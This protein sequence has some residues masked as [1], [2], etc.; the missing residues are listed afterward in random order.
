[1]KIDSLNSMWYGGPEF[2][3]LQ[4]PQEATAEG[5]AP[6]PASP[7]EAAAQTAFSRLLDASLRFTP[8]EGAIVEEAR[9]ALEAGEL[10]RPEAVRQ[11]AEKIIQRGI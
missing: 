1:M 6:K 11:A 5:I 4:K 7:D 10:D 9:K 2:Q 3:Q 8:D